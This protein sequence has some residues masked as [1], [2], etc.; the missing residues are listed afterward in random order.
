MEAQNPEDAAED[1]IYAALSGRQITV[2]LPSIWP[3]LQEFVDAYRGLMLVAMVNAFGYVAHPPHPPNGGGCVCG[4]GSEGKVLYITLSA[5]PNITPSTK[6]KAA[7]LIDDAEAVT[8]EEFRN[9]S[10]NKQHRLYQQE[11]TQLLESYE[12]HVAQMLQHQGAIS[13]TNM[14][15]M[16]LYFHN[17]VRAYMYF[18]HWFYTDDP[19]RDYSKQWNPEDWLGYMKRMVA[20]GKAWNR[21]D[22]NF[23]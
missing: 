5:I 10:T 22:V 12:N 13:R 16:K 6:G 21:E 1:A 15:V 17:G 23:S 7:F 14:C 19:W 3:R 18:K 8:I 4:P 20:K 11:N 9:S 2:P